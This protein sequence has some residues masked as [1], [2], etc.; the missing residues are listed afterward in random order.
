MF[1]WN[2]G[3][4]RKPAPDHRHGIRVAV[5]GFAL[6]GLLGSATAAVAAG[7][8]PAGGPDDGRSVE[9]PVGPRVVAA[10][11]RPRFQLPFE[12]NSRV[13]LSTYPGHDDYDIDMWLRPLAPVLASAGGTVVFGGWDSSG[14]NSVVI[15]HGGGWES[16]YI[17]MAERPLVSPG[18][19]VVAGQQL[20]KLGNT[21]GGN[22]GGSYHLHYEQI[23]NGAKTESWFNGVPSGITDDA[24]SPEK[25]LVSRNCGAN[26]P[27]EPVVPPATVFNDS[28]GAPAIGRH[29]D[30]RLELFPLSKTGGIG[31]I[32]EGVP[33]GPWSDLFS[34]G[35]NLAV[36]QALPVN[37]GDGRMEVFAVGTDGSVWNKFETSVNGS[38]SG[39]NGFAPAGSFSSVFAARHFNSN[40]LEIFGVKPD[41]SVWNK[42][43]TRVN[44]PWSDWNV[45]Y[46]DATRKIVSATVSAHADN[47]LEVFAVA[48]DGS[49]WN[50]FE[51]SPDGPWHDWESFAPAGSAAYLKT[52]RHGSGRLEVFAVKSDGSVWNRFETTK[53]GPWSGWNGFADAGTVGTDPR[54][55]NISAHHGGRLELFA[56]KPD[57]SV[58]NKYEGSPDGPWSGWNGF[59][60]AGY[61]VFVNGTR[62]SDNRLEVFA[63]AAD[64]SLNNR[65]E[66]APNAAWSAWNP[67]LPAQ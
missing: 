33:N 56:V 51:I 37:H 2:L 7:P 6:L 55:L 62:H 29:A 26:D 52:A 1:G 41:G 5:F 44:G 16:L 36:R 38:W 40:R 12:C 47:R 27:G 61:A 57:G 9:A 30:G 23:L 49:V 28:E 31:N 53:N 58:V 50:K 15:D 59:A 42:Y 32:F 46:A 35:P 4:R 25:Y 43:E 24:T 13:R 18:A 19:R 66:T 21:G 65:F 60:N 45:Y 14:G 54:A 63:T 20:G 11:A 17:H 8:R 3:R 22:P 34:F 10:A 67:F 39:W 48:A 64:G